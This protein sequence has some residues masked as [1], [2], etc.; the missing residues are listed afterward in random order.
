MT[1]EAPTAADVVAAARSLL[2]VKWV[3]QGRRA[4]AG[5]DCLGLLVEVGRRVGCT[6]PDDASYGR[7]PD[8]K[9]LLAGMRRFLIA[10][11]VGTTPRPGHA[12]ALRI[13]L[14]PHHVGFVGDYRDGVSLIH[15]NVK[16]GGVC[17]HRM[18]SHW[19]AAIVELYRLPGVTYP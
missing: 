8:G 16:A 11:P 1:V 15:G 6:V 13:G 17:E 3:H 7:L 14:N 10:E 19:I 9:E 2:R 18:T 12:V 4:D 5:L